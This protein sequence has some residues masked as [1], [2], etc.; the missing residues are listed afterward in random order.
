MIGYGWDYAELVDLSNL[1]GTEAVYMA[2][3]PNT[4]EYIHFKKTIDEV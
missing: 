2:Y 4:N 3:N 1:E